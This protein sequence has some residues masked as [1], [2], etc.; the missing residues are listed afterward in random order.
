M[1]YSKYY[2][3]H[4]NNNNNNNRF[5]FYYHDCT[6]GSYG[7]GKVTKGRSR[8]EFEFDTLQKPCTLYSYSKSDL[9]D[10]IRFDFRRTDSTKFW[11]YTVWVNGKGFKTN[12]SEIVIPKDFL[13]TDSIQVIVNTYTIYVKNKLD[14]FNEITFYLEDGWM[15]FE[16]GGKTILRKKRNKFY[17]ESFIWIYDEDDYHMENRKRRKFIYEYRMN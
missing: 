10:S 12:D 3:L 14:E 1:M 9:K 4:N 13:T 2:V 17:L 11:S 15:T 5:E 8:W 6:G 16:N 7:K